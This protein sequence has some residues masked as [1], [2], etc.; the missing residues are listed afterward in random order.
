[1]KKSV[2]I[3]VIIVVVV[4]TLFMTVSVFAADGIDIETWV[5]VD[6][7]DPQEADEAPGPL[8]PTDSEVTLIYELTGIF[9]IDTNDVNFTLT[10]DVQGELATGTLSLGSD[11]FT[12]EVVISEVL[13]GQYSSTGVVTWEGL[14]GSGEASDPVN[15]YGVPPLEEVV[16]DLK[17]GSD[18]SDPNSINLH[19]QGV[20][21]LAL[22]S[23]AEGLDV[24]TI[25]LEGATIQ[26]AGA[27]A[28]RWAIEDVNDDGLLDLIFHFRTQDLVDLTETSEF[29][30]FTISYSYEGLDD[31]VAQYSG[32]DTVNI[33]PKGNAYGHSNS[34][35]NAYAYGHSNGNGNGNGNAY[36]HNK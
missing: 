28:L 10:D 8:V 31:P 33:V 24:T 23:V 2:L 30:D 9:G 6:D 19:S 14:G 20:T 21:P 25:D 4:L 32:Q 18:P 16:I 11:T 1:M 5:Q 3:P 29:G 13:V 34:N 27:T 7:G 15:Y 36:G 35:G 22:L 26:F 17:P 12:W